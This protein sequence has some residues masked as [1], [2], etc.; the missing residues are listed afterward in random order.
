MYIFFRHVQFLLLYTISINQH[1]ADRVLNNLWTVAA[2]L[3][4][5]GPGALATRR[6]AASHLAGLLARCVR[7]PNSRLV[8][9]LKT[10][11]D[12]CHSYISAAQESTTVTDNI[13]AHGAFHAICHAVFYLI[14]FKH[15]HL[16]MSKESEY[17]LAFYILKIFIW[18]VYLLLSIF[19]VHL[20]SL[21]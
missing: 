7:V 20:Q 16:F 2:G 18:N 11:T 1:C 5:L 19:V 10:M 8:Q 6:T 21:Y 17:N 15:Q 14:A 4:G 12:W 9:F 13:K 3:Q